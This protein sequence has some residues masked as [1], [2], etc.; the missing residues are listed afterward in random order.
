MTQQGL[1]RLSTNPALFGEECISMTKAWEVYDM[2]LHDPRVFFMNE[3]EGLDS[4]WRRYTI[5]FT[6][7]PKVWNDAYLAAFAKCMDLTVV[8]LDKG[9]QQYSEL[10]YLLLRG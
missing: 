6:Y 7:S 1:L 3:P 9:F 8:T 10:K 2:L 4:L 5:P